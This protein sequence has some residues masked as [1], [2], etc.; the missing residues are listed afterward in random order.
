MKTRL[1]VLLGCLTLSNICFAEDLFLDEPR[2]APDKVFLEAK[3]HNKGKTLET[4]RPS[5][6][7]LETWT[8]MG[9]DEVQ[10]I[11]QDDKSSLDPVF[12]FYPNSEGMI[13]VRLD[14]YYPEGAIPANEKVRIRV[15]IMDR[16]TNK[17]K[18]IIASPAF[19]PKS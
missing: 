13:M 17:T 3:L 14:Y 18:V 19:T 15:T 1:L 6:F 11:E 4:S 7:V 16:D 9:W 8:E 12:H 5:F 10:R 2:F